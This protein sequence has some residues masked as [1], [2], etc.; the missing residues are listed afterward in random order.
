VEKGM[1]RGVATKQG[2]MRT[3]ILRIPD[4]DHL[5]CP[6]QLVIPLEVNQGG[7]NVQDDT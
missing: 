6:L 5:V 3:V 1:D 7:K 4:E 2:R